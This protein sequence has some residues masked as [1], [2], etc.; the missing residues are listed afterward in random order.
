MIMH[1]IQNGGEWKLKRPRPLPGRWQDTTWRRVEKNRVIKPYK[2][3]DTHQEGSAP[4]M[5]GKPSSHV[6]YERLSCLDQSGSPFITTRI[7]IC[8]RTDRQIEIEI[9]HLIIIGPYLTLP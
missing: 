7:S 2:A 4:K 5:V 8:L 6:R 1:P 9:C 3:T